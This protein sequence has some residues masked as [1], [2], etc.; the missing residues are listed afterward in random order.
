M[1]IFFCVFFLLDGT[2]SLCINRENYSNFIFNEFRCPLSPIF[3]VNNRYC[4]GPFHQQYCC[5][6]WERYF[7]LFLS[8][9]WFF[10]FR[11][12]PSL[13]SSFGFH[14]L[15]FLFLSSVVAS[16]VAIYQPSNEYAS[17][18]T[19]V[20]NSSKQ[21]QLLFSFFFYSRFFL[22]CLRHS[23]DAHPLDV[24]TVVFILYLTEDLE[25]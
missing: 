6:F 22:F 13:Y 3:T 14:S 12:C 19:T 16:L 15:S 21:T 11:R 23:I 10:F 24:Y 4:C 9:F 8:S 18:S 17:C 7:S 5:S 2:G 1:I 25:S 20:N